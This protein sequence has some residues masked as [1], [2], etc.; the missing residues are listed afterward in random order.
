MKFKN[1]PDSCILINYKEEG[2]AIFR[3]KEIKEEG[4]MRVVV[5]EYE[6]TAS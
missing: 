3:L 4:G 1:K 5:Y 6:G 2:Y